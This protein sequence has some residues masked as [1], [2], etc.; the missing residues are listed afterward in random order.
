MISSA[1]LTIKP[2]KSETIT[3][4]NES[5]PISYTIAEA[6]NACNLNWTAD[7]NTV[8][9][10]MVFNALPLNYYDTLIQQLVSCEDWVNVLRVKRFS[11]IDGYDSPIIEQATR[12]AL[13]ELPM[14]KNLPLTWQDG[15]QSYFSVR[16]RFVLN[17]YRYAPQYNLTEKWNTTAA[18]QDL[19]ITYQAAG[20]PS[21][22]YNP[23]DSVIFQWQPRYYDEAAETLDAF[24]KLNDEDADLW[25]YIQDTFW[26]GRIYGYNGYNSKYEYECEVGSFAIIIGNYYVARGQTLPNFDRV[27]LDL[28]NKLLAQGLQSVAWGIPGVLSHSETNHELRLENTLIAIQ[29][30]HAYT[31]LSSWKNDFADLLNETKAA[32][33]LLNSPLYSHGTFRSTNQTEFSDI[34][35]AEGMMT[36]F[37]EGIIPETGSLAMPLNDEGYQEA[38]WLSSASLFGFD[39]PKSTIRIP[40]NVGNLTFQ[41][42]T[43]PVSYTF[44]RSGVYEV[45]FDQ[46]WNSILNVIK[47]GSLDTQ[48][49]Y[50]PSPITLPSA[51][52]S[53]AETLALANQSLTFDAST[54]VPGSNRSAPTPI[55]RYVW[56]F[57]DG[58]TTDTNSSIISHVYDFG[59]TYQV[60]LLVKDKEGF[61]DSTSNLL[62]VYVPLTLSYSVQGGAS[63]FLAPQL[64]YTFNG[65]KQTST[66]SSSTTMYALDSGTSW[67]IKN[68]ASNLSPEERWQTTQQ[69]GGI[70][71]VP[72]TKEIL[73]HHQYLVTAAYSVTGNSP[74]QP[75]KLSSTA[76]SSPAVHLLTSTPTKIWLDS[77]AAYSTPSLLSCSNASERWLSDSAA[78][79]TISQPQN[80]AVQ[81]QHQ[82]FVTNQATPPIG[83]ETQPDSGWYDESVSLQLVASPNS[84][85]QFENWSGSGAGAY[86]GASEVQ[87]ITVG[88]AINQTAT[89]L[90][91]LT[92]EASEQ[93]SVSYA[94]ANVSGELLHGSSQTVYA[95]YGTN[96]TL[97]A[98]SASFFYVFGSWSGA[99]ESGNSSVCLLL[100]SPLDVRATYSYNYVNIAFTLLSSLGAII[101]FLV[102]LVKRQAAHKSV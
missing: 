46:N 86:S 96:I 2:A 95:P 50:F 93:L 73:Y 67:S 7:P 41:F 4:Q 61:I 68:P 74:P 35:T 59:G 13:I 8:K 91:G 72:Q 16:N 75:P 47:L 40:V 101:V 10:A 100:G 20:K 81:Y 92:V 9:F 23:L 71:S 77:G 102:V 37:L 19:L 49:T 83:G 64:T 31:G 57:G 28:Y 45:Q 97:T 80:I 51:N 11:E 85:W 34:A 54:S 76:F 56:D 25:N 62:P 14:L 94:Y 52:F 15:D 1:F 27:Y 87:S 3:T 98:T 60:S 24:V 69:T 6:I 22:G 66:L 63:G 26:G 42:G 29:A 33:A 48:F 5:I 55:T 82:F 84:G 70:A 53:W 44:P 18:Y 30:L 32:T 65:T 79:G 43:N 39:Y 21:L 88:G 36:L 58:N 12:Q 99:V 89:F 78:Q 17:A 90:A 38:C